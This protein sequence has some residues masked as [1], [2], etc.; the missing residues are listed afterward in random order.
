MLRNLLFQA[1]V[2]N[3]WMQVLPR[4]DHTF[5]VQRDFQDNT[6]DFHVPVSLL[7][8]EFGSFLYQYSSMDPT[9]VT[10]KDMKFVQ[11]LIAEM[12]QTYYTEDDRRAAFKKLLSAYFEENVGLDDNTD[13]LIAV[14]HQGVRFIAYLQEIKNE[15]GSVKQC[16]DY[17][18]KAILK[19]TK[20]HCPCLVVILCGATLRVLGIVSTKAK[21]IC[22]WLVPTLKLAY[23]PGSVISNSVCICMTA[24]KATLIRLMVYYK[25]NPI[26]SS[27]FP[28]FCSYTN[29]DSKA[30]TIEYIDRLERLVYEAIATI[31]D[32]EDGE[33]KTDV[34]VKF[35]E[36]YGEAV[37]TFMAER[38]LSPP[39]FTVQKVR[40]TIRYIFGYI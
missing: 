33:K 24:L 11:H 17:Y 3:S 29:K 22:E 12:V 32:N 14:M 4:V 37:H 30:V 19:I 13:G 38:H 27:T 15:E 6:A 34:I 36:S 28:Y 5:D 40:Y 1:Q 7:C 35:A 18:S 39:I 20:Y 16:L 21:A 23:I 31:N 10:L 2:I 26:I 9:T 8:K 25:T